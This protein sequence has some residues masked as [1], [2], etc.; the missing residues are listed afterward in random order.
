MADN[1]ITKFSEYYSK[2]DAFV[3]NIVLSKLSIFNNII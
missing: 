2:T 3:Y 1:T